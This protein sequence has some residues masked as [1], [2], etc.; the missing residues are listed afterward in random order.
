MF[1]KTYNEVRA[2]LKDYVL[3]DS[4]ILA[5]LPVE[6]LQKEVI[7]IGRQR[8]QYSAEYFGR[9][10]TFKLLSAGGYEY[11]W[12]ANNAFED[13]PKVYHVI[14][15]YIW[16]F[17][18]LDESKRNTRKDI[19]LTCNNDQ[20]YCHIMTFKCSKCHAIILGG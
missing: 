15:E 1:F 13:S 9:F 5:R 6:E 7:Y 20:L 17:Q 16:V 12:L 19:C 3:S 14:P 11:I 18:K 2:F 10:F 4:S 8:E